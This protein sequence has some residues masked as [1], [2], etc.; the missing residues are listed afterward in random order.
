MKGD[1]Q[2]IVATNAFGMGIDK[3]D[4]RY[5]IHYNMPGSLEAYYQ[6]AG[7][8][9]RR[10]GIA[11][12][13]VLLFSYQ[14]RYIQEFFIDNGYP[15]ASMVQ[16]IYEYLLQIPDDP[17]EMTQQEIRENLDLSLSS[18]AVGTALQWISRTGVLERLE[19]GAGWPWFG[20]PAI[21]RRWWICCQRPRSVEGRYFEY[22]RGLS[23]IVATKLFMSTLDG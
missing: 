20:S 21:F 3:A 4:L 18:E 22:W 19:A 15:P 17:I 10:E 11:S 14:D 2:A 9:A 12:C 13:N 16:S 7:G 6:E 1:L 8:Q 5:V 23:G